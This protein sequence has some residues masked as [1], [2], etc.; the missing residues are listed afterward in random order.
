MD[1]EQIRKVSGSL[2]HSGSG[3]S[4]V[5]FQN[6]DATAIGFEH[7][8]QSVLDLSESGHRPMCLVEFCLS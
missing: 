6:G 2:Q 8:P 4:A 3:D 7:M 1:E 5:V